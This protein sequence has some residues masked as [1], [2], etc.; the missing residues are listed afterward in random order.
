MLLETIEYKEDGSESEPRDMIIHVVGYG[1]VYSDPASGVQGIPYLAPFLTSLLNK[2]VG[3]EVEIDL[4][5]G[6]TVRQ[7]IK[8]LSNRLEKLEAQM[9][10]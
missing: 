7:R 5:N 2:S 1:E 4:P 6:K 8:Q 3:D 9:A 10:R